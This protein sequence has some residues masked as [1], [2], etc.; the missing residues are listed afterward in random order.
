MSNSCHPRSMDSVASLPAMV[1][2]SLTSA[3]RKVDSLFASPPVLAHVAVLVACTVLTRLPLLG[4]GEPDSALITTGL[5]QWVR[6]GAHAPGIY[7]A[8]VCSAYYWAVALIVRLFHIVEFDYARML[9]LLSTVAGVGIAV[10]SYLLGC[11][12]M[13]PRAAFW[14]TLT[15][16][17]SPGLWWTTIEP[18]P[19]AVSTFFS[20]LGVFFFWKYLDRGGWS[21]MVASACI[22]G[23]AVSVKI[24]SILAFPFL[25]AIVWFTRSRKMLAACVTALSAMAVGLALGRLILGS[26]VD[27]VAAASAASA[28]FFTIPRGISLFKQA[29]PVVCGPGIV[30]FVVGICCTVFFVVRERSRQRWLGFIL[31]WSFPGYLFWILIAGNNVRHVIP[32]FMPILWLAARQLRSKHLVAALA[33]GLLIPA[34]SN[35][36]LFPAPNVPLSFRLFTGKQRQLEDISKQLS[37]HGGCFVGSYTNDYLTDM[38]AD[39][40]GYMVVVTGEQLDFSFANGAMVNVFRTSPWK[41]SLSPHQKCTSLE[42]D[43]GA[44]TRFLGSEWN[45]WF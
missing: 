33:L 25:A 17:M 43:S 12:M 2:P 31:L 3:L 40:G 10:V 39:K 7:S 8:E 35:M 41:V 18:H 44:K 27:S 29:A 14:A 32:F 34:N 21:W 9:S 22:L 28:F 26:V 16:L 4:I 23:L 19:Q 36:F 20:L 6:Y 30:V 1:E 24:D 5:R 38:L 37:A 42:Y 15:L 13:L 45:Q 11:K